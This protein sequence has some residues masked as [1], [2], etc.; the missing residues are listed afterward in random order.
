M[1]NPSDVAN[2]S[3][4]LGILLLLITLFISA[5]SASL[6]AQ[7][8]RQGGS[9]RRECWGIMLLSSAL[10]LV[11]TLTM[12]FLWPAIHDVLK[13]HGTSDWKNSFRLFIL[14]YLLLMPLW[15]WEVQIGYGALV[16]VFQK[17]KRP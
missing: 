11:T 9:N 4:S 12:Y 14:V 7:N 13:A 5:L 6:D 2:I 1:I 17:L 10:V 8:L 3:S 15:F 16:N